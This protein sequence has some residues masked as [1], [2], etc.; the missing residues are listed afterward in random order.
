MTLVVATPVDGA[1]IWSARV[2]L[3]YAEN[4]RM[5]SHEMPVATVVEYARDVVRARNRV[6]SL[7][8]SEF[9]AMTHVLWWDDDQWPEDRGIV[10]KMID[11]GEDLIGAP[12]TSKMLPLRWV[13]QLLHP[14]P[15]AV[16]GV[17]AVRAVG[18]GF[19]LT[20]RRCLEDMTAAHRKYRDW[21]RE[22]RPANLF[23]Q[24]Y[25]SPMLSGGLYTP[26]DEECLLSEDF[27][28]CKRW[29]DMGRK[30]AILCDGGVIF[31]AGPRGWSAKDLGPRVDT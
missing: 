9:P 22:T 12:Y 4:L 6:A 26:E 2:T 11:S 16:G 21:P 29:R 17:Q 20:T 10:R 13:H 5:L 30:V 15:V 8:L 18:F 25:E 27:S 19:T 3:G 31:H 28:F 7:V 24:L 14:C 1:D 23:G